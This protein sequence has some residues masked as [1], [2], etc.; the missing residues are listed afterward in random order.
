MSESW[1]GSIA[2]GILYWFRFPDPSDDADDV[3]SEYELFQGEWVQIEQRVGW[4]RAPH[5][6]NIYK[7]HK[8]LFKSI[9]LGRPEETYYEENLDSGEF[10]SIMMG[11][12]DLPSDHGK[13]KLETTIE[14]NSAP[15][16]DNN[17]CEV[18]YDVETYLMYNDIPNG[19]TFLPRIVARPLNR[20]LKWA[21]YFFVAEEMVEHD[22]EFAREKLNS[23]FQYIH[24]YHG[25]EPIQ[26]KSRQASFKPVPEK[27]IF[28]Q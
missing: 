16:G 3:W 6:P 10:K 28:W 27:G 11:F 5:V 14:T 26:T 24:R 19:V 25:E 18:E 13:M 23:Y 22:G 21:F 12:H 15:S 8:P 4:Y 20:F 2:E 9:D 7:D 17:F 1:L